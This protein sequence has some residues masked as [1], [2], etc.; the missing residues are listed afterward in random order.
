MT[1]ATGGY[2]SARHNEIRDLLASA[3]AEVCPDVETE[4][5][6]AC[7]N[8]EVV[9]GLTEDGARVDIRARGFWTR[10][11]NAFF[12]VRVT[13][14]GSALLSRSEVVSQLSK[15]EREKKR[16]Y[17]ERIINVDRGS[18]TLL[19]FATNGQSATEASRFLKAL[20]LAIAD[21]NRD[22]SYAQVMQYLRCRVSFCLLRWQ[23]TCLRG[24]RRRQRGRHQFVAECQQLA[25]LL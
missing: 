21:K 3:V 14:P 13:H 7:L 17:G 18:F 10:Q 9:N 24:S 23:I 12:D 15:H 5:R 25:N 22:L 16:N 20:A 4:P 2:P 1:C 19:V 8:G 6:L 11:Q